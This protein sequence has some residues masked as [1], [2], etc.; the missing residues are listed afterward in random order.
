M[1][2]LGYATQP[3]WRRVLSIQAR[4]MTN[5]FNKASEQ[6]EGGSAYPIQ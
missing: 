1:A 5:N 3:Q 2:M 6:A 4:T